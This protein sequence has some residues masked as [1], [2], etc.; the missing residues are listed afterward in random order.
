MDKAQGVEA[1]DVPRPAFRLRAEE[2]RL[3]LLVGDLVAASIATLIA[4]AGWA[5]FDWLGFTQEFVRSR[6][7]WFVFTPLVWVALLVGL[8]DLHR[9]GS[10]RETWTG[11]L[12]AAAAGAVIY[13]VAY[14]T[15]QGSLARRGVLYFLVFA[16]VLTLIWRRLY[17]AATQG[18]GMARR[19]L[20]VGAGESGR[21]ILQVLGGL[22]HP[23]LQ[24]VAVLD[25]DPVKREAILE[26][27]PIIGGHH[28]LLPR[29]ERDGVTDVIVAITGPMNSEMFQALL[30]A[31]ERGA[32]ITRMPVAY[33]EWLGK[34]PIQHLESDWLLRSFVDEVRVGNLYELGRRWIDVAGALLGLA[35]F[36]LVLPWAALAI[37]LESGRPIFYAQKR[38]GRGGRPYSIVKLR[39]MR[40]NGEDGKG[41]PWPS[42]EDDIRMTRV[43]WILRRTHL[44]EFPQFWNVLRG[45][46]SLVGPRPEQ[47][48]LV[49][50]LEKE[51]PFYRARL[52]VKPGLTGWAQVNYGKGASVEGSAEKLE[53]D[54]Y[55]IKHR[56]F[57]LDMW[58]ILRTIGAVIGLR[59]V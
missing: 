25:D 31:Q 58:I 18:Q 43:G 50:E 59:G 52:L 55:Y 39:T 5:Q 38:V 8:Y 49:A 11:I 21:T 53:Y 37:G 41:S 15:L 17:I 47:V 34:V 9:A 14:F 19:A 4:L 20:V 10:W 45:E 7:G 3:I 32:E 36:V 57:L 28:E 2:R 22:Q 29:I 23:P 26:G 12:K 46:M 24:V 40:S 13:L 51:I 1:R 44:D 6:A 30:D 54:L 48:D 33:E 42:S 56:G 27:I 16:V 35:L